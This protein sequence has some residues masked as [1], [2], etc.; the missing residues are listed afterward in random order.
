M[1]RSKSNPICRIPK[2]TGDNTPST[3]GNGSLS[4]AWIEIHLVIAMVG[5]KCRAL[6]HCFARL[7][8]T[9]NGVSP[10]LSPQ[11]FP[12]VGG[13]LELLVIEHDIVGA[14]V[15]EQSRLGAVEV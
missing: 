7:D 8:Q 15:N 13:A 3:I 5:T 12:V 6:E 1:W 4:G 14:G 9:A 10:N 11:Q 2:A